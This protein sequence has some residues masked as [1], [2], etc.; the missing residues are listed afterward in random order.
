MDERLYF[1]T[2]ITLPNGRKKIIRL[3]DG[4]CGGISVCD[5]AYNEIQEADSI[6]NLVGIL[7]SFFPGWDTEADLDFEESIQTDEYKAS[8][9]L[10]YAIYSG[11]DKIRKG[12]Y[13]NGNEDERIY[14]DK[15]IQR[16]SFDWDEAVKMA[17]ALS[18][19]SQIAVIDAD[20]DS[21]GQPSAYPYV[22]E[23]RR[24]GEDF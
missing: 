15:S 16:G 2:T 6:N 1:S 23:V 7:H 3:A 5:E 24:N 22:L 20:F 8:R 4:E 21:N 13:L 11:E 14:L 18:E 19:N 9:R 12:R 10:W 17:K